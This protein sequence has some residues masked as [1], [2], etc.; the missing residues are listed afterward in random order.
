MTSWRIRIFHMES[1]YLIYGG[2]FNA[3]VTEVSC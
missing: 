1:Y 3:K 2:V